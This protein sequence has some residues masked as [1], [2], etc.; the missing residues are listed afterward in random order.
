MALFKLG[1]HC[2]L[3]VII[4]CMASCTSVSMPKTL[5]LELGG[6]QGIE[7]LVDHLIQNIGK[8]DQIFHYF[9]ETKISRFRQQLEDHFC[10]IGDGPC[11]YQGDSMKEVHAGMHIN[12]ADFN[13]LVELLIAAMTDSQLPQTTQN[14][15]LQRLAPL[16][17]NIIG[18]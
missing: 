10:A 11:I 18:R 12:E 6:K 17:Q 1:E 9:A 8:D 4:L 5:Y 3:I 7:V 15:L 13:R 2:C 14:K 16:R